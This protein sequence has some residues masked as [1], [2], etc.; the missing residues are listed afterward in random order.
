MCQASYTGVIRLEMPNTISYRRR[1]GSYVIHLIDEV[2]HRTYAVLNSS[3]DILAVG[4]V[5]WGND[6][7][8]VS[9][10]AGSLPQDFADG[11]AILRASYDMYLPASRLSE[12]GNP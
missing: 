12:R 1:I 10:D 6:R 5:D 9:V 8:P 3:N 4:K 11:N 7:G 2:V